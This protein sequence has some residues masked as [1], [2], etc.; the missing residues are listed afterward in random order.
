MMDI[1]LDKKH[2]INLKKGNTISLVK[3]DTVLQHVCVGLNWGAIPRKSS[4]WSALLPRIQVDLDGSVAM[5]SESGKLLDTVSFR[6]LRST[7]GSIVHS[8]DD[9]TGDLFGDDGRDNE[10][11]QVSLNKVHPKVQ[12][13]V[14]FLNSFR[15]QDFATIPYSKI[16]IYE[17]TPRRVRNVVAT[18]NLSA[19]EQY[20][21]YV[22][23][24]MGKMYRDVNGTWK[25]KSIGEPVKARNIA[26]TVDVIKRDYLAA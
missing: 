24:I 10:V 6:K 15:Q 16:R 2:G 19:E 12:E 9:L 25:F 13:I 18:F 22:S 14:F 20:S 21:G 4:F 7:D 11:L 8:G 17:G 23:M 26:Q 1:R 5:F 3:D